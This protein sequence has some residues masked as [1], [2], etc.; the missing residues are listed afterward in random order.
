MRT[1]CSGGPFSVRLKRTRD[2]CAAHIL[3]LHTAFCRTFVRINYFRENNGK[4]KIDAQSLPR[5]EKRSSDDLLPFSAGTSSLRSDDLRL[6]ESDSA[7][8]FR[9]YRLS[10]GEVLPSPNVS[11]T[12]FAI[13]ISVSPRS[14]RTTVLLRRPT[15]LRSANNISDRRLR[16]SVAARSSCI[17]TLGA[18]VSPSQDRP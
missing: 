10:A 11:F 3:G 2:S 18:D 15:L 1:I 4:R 7:S 12:R 9:Q 14:L 5:P 13:R 16:C 17:P 8:L 6:P